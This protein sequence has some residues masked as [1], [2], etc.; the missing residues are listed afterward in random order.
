MPRFLVTAGLLAG[1]FS[2]SAAIGFG[3]LCLL[4][5]A[6]LLGGIGILFYRG[7]ILALLAAIATGLLMAALI[8]RLRRPG[9]QLR[10]AAAAAIV[11][12]SLN[13]AFLVVVPVTVDRSISV[14]LLGRLASTGASA[15]TADEVRRMFVD[16]YVGEQRQ[17]ERRLDEQLA[18]GNI[19][20]VGERYRI[21]A[22]GLAFIRTAQA[23]AWL[24]DT[25]TRLVA[26]Q[27]ASNPPPAR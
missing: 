2:G 17:I 20:R 22:Q 14:F 5:K 4:F 21:S 15:Y 10:D 9:L 7:L 12:F 23:A 3:L 27:P 8:A 1:V 18:S 26:P 25:D 16:G 19:E 13:V 11:S 24:F 6:G